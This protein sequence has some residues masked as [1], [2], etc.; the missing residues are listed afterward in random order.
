MAFDLIERLNELNLSLPPAPKPA[1]NY[2]PCARVGDLIHVSGQLPIAEGEPI[3]R[4]AV[5]GPVDLDTAR[6]AAA[7]CVMNGLAAVHHTFHGDWRRFR[8]VVRVGVFVASTHDHHEQH[9]VANGASDRLVEIFSDAGRHAR[10]AVGVAS[11]P[12]NACVEVE[13]TLQWSG[14]GEA[15]GASER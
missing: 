15:A 13:M 12:L 4:G 14:V 9:L 10:A 5:G 1:A 11:L 6:R 8:R 7:Q 3:A 2:D